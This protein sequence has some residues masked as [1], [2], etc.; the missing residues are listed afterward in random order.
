MWSKELYLSLP[1]PPTFESIMEDVDVSVGE[2][3]HFAVVVE[4]S[5]VP[6]ILWFKV[7]DRKLCVCLHLCLC[8][9]IQKRCDLMTVVGPR[10][11]MDMIN[12]LTWLC[13]LSVS[14]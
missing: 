6:D 13:Y 5:P 1:A 10:I 9:L 8:H 14:G 2:T 12:F 3:P 4:G 11:E 7:H